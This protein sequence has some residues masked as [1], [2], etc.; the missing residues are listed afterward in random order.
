MGRSRAAPSRGRD[1]APRRGPLPGRP[2]PGPERT[3]CR[4]PALAARARADRPARSGGRA[5]APWG[6]RSAHRGGRRRHV[7]PVPGRRGR[8]APLLRRRRRDGALRGRARRRRRGEGPLRGRGRARADRGRLRAARR[9]C[10]TPRRARSSP[11]ASSPTA[12]P[13]RPSRAPPWSWRRR[14][15]SHAGRARRSSAT[16]SSPTGTQAA[17]RA[18]R[19]GELPGPVHA[20]LR[21][22]G[23]ARAPRRE[24]ADHHAARLGRELRDQVDDLRLHR[25]HGPRVA[26]ARRAGALDRGSPRAPGRQLRLDRAH[27]RRAGRLLRRGRAA[28]GR[29]RRGRG[30]RRLRPRAGAG[31]AL[32]DARLALG[33]LPGAE[34]G[35]PQPRRPRRTAARPGSTAASAGRSSTSR[36]RAR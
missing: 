31:D 22:R 26:Q 32:P 8:R 35:L 24:A 36:S 11:S 14:S 28:G 5:G 6:R 29:L 19:L 4:D 15:P 20:A 18:H 25:A 21:R 3:P 7:E 9:R 1:P 2:R 10:S 34:R 13:T 12:T 16:A 23:R 27:H 30:R 33:R 17:G